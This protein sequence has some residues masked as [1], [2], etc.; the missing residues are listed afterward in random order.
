MQNYYHPTTDACWFDLSPSL[1][2][3]T[4]LK[5]DWLEGQWYIS[6]SIDMRG[7]YDW[8]ESTCNRL[9]ITKN[10]TQNLYVLQTSINNEL[11]DINTM[12][13]DPR[14]TTVFI[15]NFAGD[16]SGKG[17]NIHVIFHDITG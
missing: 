5:P 1:A 6:A 15:G 7:V 3:F 10:D 8:S 4:F 17:K 2:K 13:S 16:W 12:F 14:N 9:I 11:K